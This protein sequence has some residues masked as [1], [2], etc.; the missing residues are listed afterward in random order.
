MG[1]I[2]A[3]S[4]LLNSSNNAGANPN[5]MRTIDKPAAKSENLYGNAPAPP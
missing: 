3:H 4:T 1:K 2:K 5:K